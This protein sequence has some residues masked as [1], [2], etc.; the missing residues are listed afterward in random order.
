M[1][2]DGLRRP[3]GRSRRI[4]HRRVR[5]GPLAVADCAGRAHS[6]CRMACRQ[7]RDART[8][9][10]RMLRLIALIGAVLAAACGAPNPAGWTIQI[11]R[12]ESPAGPHSSEPQ[13]AVSGRGVLVSWIEHSGTNTILKFAE[14]T[15]TGWT[16]PVTVASGADW[17]LSYADVPSVMRESDGTLVA[18]WLKT[19]DPKV[20]GYD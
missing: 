13:L 19:T 20:E 2:H 8:L 16:Q 10:T 6:V 9:R 15:G 1:G 18:Q 3:T 4:R 11:D 14:R 17:F 7:R 12:T 5:V